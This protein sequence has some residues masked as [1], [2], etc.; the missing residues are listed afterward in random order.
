MSNEEKTKEKKMTLT[1]F[2]NK[3]KPDHSGFITLTFNGGIEMDSTEE[4]ALN[5]SQYLYIV[6]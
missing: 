1:L 5:G 2:D 3:R 4:A 6:N